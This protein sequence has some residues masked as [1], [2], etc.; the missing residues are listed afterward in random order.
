MSA[1]ALP[2]SNGSGFFRKKPASDGNSYLYNFLSTFCTYLFSLVLAGTAS[3]SISLHEIISFNI[4]H[5]SMFSLLGLVLM[6]AILPVSSL[7]KLSRIYIALSVHS[8][9][10]QLNFYL[11]RLYYVQSLPYLTCWPTRSN[12]GSTSSWSA[13]SKATRISLWICDW[14]ISKC[15]AF[16]SK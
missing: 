10:D 14:S 9:H 5:I 12:L 7:Y 3:W 15:P 16:N 6:S 2:I 1:F 4:F 11:I 8:I 13:Y